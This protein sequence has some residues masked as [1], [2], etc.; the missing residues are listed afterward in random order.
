MHQW[1]QLKGNPAAC[2]PL[3]TSSGHG[4]VS[5]EVAMSQINA[6]DSGTSQSPKC[7]VPVTMLPSLRI[8]VWCEVVS[9]GCISPVGSLS[10][11]KYVV[12]YA[13]NT[14][15]PLAGRPPFNTGP[16]S[17]PNSIV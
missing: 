14:K 17:T 11:K 8:I 15:L 4:D 16:L 12:K 10:F 7:G 6:V 3:T 5:E 2:I 13:R 9:D 1:L